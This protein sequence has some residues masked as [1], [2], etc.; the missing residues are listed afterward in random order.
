MLKKLTFAGIL[1]ACSLNTFALNIVVVND[2]SYDTKNV[3]QLKLALESAG[4]DVLMS[5]PCA[6]QSGKGGSM[7]SYLAPVPVHKLTADVDGVL[8]IDDAAEHA[9]GYCVGDTEAEKATKTF[10]E[11]KDG[12]P[13]MASAHG[14]YL[15]NQKWGQNPDLVISGPNEGQNVGFAVFISGTLGAAHYAI[16]NG[17]PAIAVSAGATPATESDALV[18]AKMVADVTLKIVDQLA[19][20]QRSGEPLL[21]DKTGLN[22]NLPDYAMLS[23]AKF[24]LTDVN[25]YFGSALQWSDLGAAGGYGSYYGYPEGAGLFGLNFFPGQDQS[26]DDS[27]QSEGNAI[28][29]GYIAISTIDATENA[30]AHKARAV[31][32]KLFGLIKERG[33]H[34]EHDHH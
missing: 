33:Q 8:N 16:V 25:W 15:A 6:H 30:P 32:K 3:Q 5:V 21:A 9:D 12:T 24:K 28:Q 19:T 7:G 2:D 31:A 26:G 27:A 20:K 11:Y 13:L 34:H 1:A 22:V 10:K 23:G 17:V 14:L 18:H 4:H 29:A